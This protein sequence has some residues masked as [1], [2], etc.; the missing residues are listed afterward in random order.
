M[1]FC[2][3][4]IHSLKGTV[5]EFLTRYVWVSV[6]EPPGSG[7]DP[8]QIKR[9]RLGLRLLVNCKAENYEFVTTKKKIFSSLIQKVVPKVEHVNSV[10]L[11]QGRK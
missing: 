1:Q 4:A 7:S 10:I 3:I 5:H 8:S 2:F 11:Y 6:S 9:L